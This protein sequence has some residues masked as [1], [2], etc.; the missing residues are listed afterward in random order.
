MPSALMAPI[1]GPLR[2]RQL[3]QIEITPSVLAPAPLRSVSAG[4]R[5]MTAA[6]GTAQ[7][8]LARHGVRRH[9]RT[10]TRPKDVAL[11]IAVSPRRSNVN[12]EDRPEGG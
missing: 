5:A 12:A 9:C 7:C 1:L 3:P 8:A 6:A 4:S 11:G 10:V 2:R